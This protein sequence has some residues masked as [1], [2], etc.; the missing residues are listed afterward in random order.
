MDIFWRQFQDIPHYI[1]NRISHWPYTRVYSSFY[2]SHLR[3]LS[4]PGQ[5]NHLW[6]LT[7]WPWNR[8]LACRRHVGRLWDIA[9]DAPGDR[10]GII[11]WWRYIFTHLRVF[12][13]CGHDLILSLTRGNDFISNSINS[14]DC[15]NV[16][17]IAI[18]SFFH[19]LLYIL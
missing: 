2:L 16:F 9:L 19:Y 4:W 12:D 7:C 1:S 5:I 13:V 15:K 10:K 11:W 6:G 14:D 17:H 8:R 3:G 18:N